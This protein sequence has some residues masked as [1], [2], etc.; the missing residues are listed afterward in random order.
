[1]FASC[2]RD[3]IPWLQPDWLIDTDG[4]E[5]VIGHVQERPTWYMEHLRKEEPVGAL[6][7]R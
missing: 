6:V 2:H 1:V 4:G 7:L 5:F 3:I